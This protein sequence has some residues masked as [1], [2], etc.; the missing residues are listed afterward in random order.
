MK[1]IDQ[2]LSATGMQCADCEN[3]IEE[4]INALPGIHSVNADFT[5][6]SLHI[7]YDADIISLNTICAAI[8]KVGYTCGQSTPPP[9]NGFVKRLAWIIS[10]AAGIALLFQLDSLFDLGVSATDLDQNLDYGLLFVVGVFTSFHCIGMCG[11]FV[12]G[13]TASAAR[14]GHSTWLNHLAYGL[15]KTLSYSAF[16]AVF[17]LLGSAVTF[18]VGTRSLAAGLAGGFLIIY[19]LSMTDAFAGLRR[20]HIRLPK[21]LAHSLL[22]RRQKISNPLLIGLLNGLMIACGPLQAMYILAAGTGNP[23]QGAKMLFVFAVGTLP[24]M[25][26]FGYLTSLITA[27]TTKKLLKISGFII[28]TLGAVMLNRSLLIAGSGWDFNSLMS[29][30]SQTI[31]H[32]FMTWQHHADVGA[33]L[34]QGYQVIY[35]EVEANRYLPNHFTLR[36]DI[37]VKWIINVKTLSTCN[38]RIVIPSLNKTIDLKPGLQIVELTPTRSG[39]ISWSCSMGMIPGTFVIED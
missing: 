4:T 6:E 1:I 29:R 20:F 9:K 15:G 39:V 16:G 19:G 33:H 21:F 27:N 11:G 18:T 24:V 22:V 38:K 13:Y 32:R 37:P 36:K 30:A 3:V 10:A 5:T 25:F 35:M 8:E 12:I 26:A 14:S 2:R 31:H 28:M 17:G 34:Q 7:A 23:W